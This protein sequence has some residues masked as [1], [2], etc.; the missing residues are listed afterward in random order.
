MS[1]TVTKRKHGHWLVTFDESS[2][3]TGHELAIEIGC[4]ADVTITDFEW[5]LESGAAATIT[6]S[7]GTIT[8]H[9]AGSKGRLVTYT[10]DDVAHDNTR[11]RSSRVAGGKLYL[12][13]EPNAG[14]N[15]RVTGAFVVR[16]GHGL[17]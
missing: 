5:S 1:A 10:A 14:A 16:N 15:N 9:T 11:V 6:P 8:G 3:A 4:A 2:V 17:N 7:L 12:Q 13:L